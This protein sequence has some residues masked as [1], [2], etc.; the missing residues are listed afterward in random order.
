MTASSVAD[1]TAADVWN[2][3]EPTNGFNNQITPTADF[4]QKFTFPEPSPPVS[5]V[6]RQ[7]LDD[8][9]NQTAGSFSSADYEVQNA[10]HAHTN[11]KPYI[12]LRRRGAR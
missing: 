11:G 3:P 12:L 6:V 4:Q 5:I 1:P 2:D 9:T 8:V 7:D 10:I